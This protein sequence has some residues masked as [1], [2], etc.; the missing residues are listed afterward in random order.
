M[1]FLMLTL[2]HTLHIAGQDGTLQITSRGAFT[3]LFSLPVNAAQSNGRFAVTHTLDFKAFMAD[4]FIQSVSFIGPVLYQCPLFTP[5]DDVLSVVMFP[6]FLLAEPLWPD[7]PSWN[8]DVNMGVVSGWISFVLPLMDCGYRTQTL[9][10]K[11][12]V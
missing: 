3:A 8:N 6:V 10:R 4:P 7:S 2:P 9:D 1:C 5:N 11:S 12:V